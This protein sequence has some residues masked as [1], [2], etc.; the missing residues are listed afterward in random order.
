MR[1]FVVAETQYPVAKALLLPLATSAKLDE[2][3]FCCL[4]SWH[5]ARLFPPQPRIMGF[6]ARP[7]DKIDIAEHVLVPKKLYIKLS[8]S[9]SFRRSSAR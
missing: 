4:N 9:D 3:D 2:I 8:A 5:S 6:S 7:D 1:G